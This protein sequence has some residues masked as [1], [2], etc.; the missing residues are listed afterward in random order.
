MRSSIANPVELR[1]RGFAAL[2]RAL[3]W[4]DAVRFLQQFEPGHGNYTEERRRILP[5]WDAE[6]LV[7]RAAAT[8]VRPGGRGRR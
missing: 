7:E 1:E 6:T 3:G 5:D 2:V 4:V 8:A